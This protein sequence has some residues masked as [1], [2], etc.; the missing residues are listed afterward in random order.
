[1][2][3]SRP[4]AV[5]RSPQA[6]L[7]LD[8]PSASWSHVTIEREEDG[9]RVR[10]AGSTNGTLVDG[11]EVDADGLLVEDEAVV[12]AG[13]TAITLRRELVET[14]APAPGTLHNLTTAGTAPFNRPP[15]PGRPPAPEP[16]CSRRC[17]RTR[18]RRPASASPPSSVR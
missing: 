18:R 9:V 16:R 14:P 3:G 15:R 4:L 13:G 2:P 11:V 1:M 8:S 5:G 12:V 10:D 6:D 17:T 7:T